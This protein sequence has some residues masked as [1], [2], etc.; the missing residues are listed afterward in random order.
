M[1]LDFTADSQALTIQ[2][3]L[4][5]KTTNDE[6]R[7]ELVRNIITEAFQHGTLSFLRSADEY[8][9]VFTFT[10]HNIQGW[11]EALPFMAMLL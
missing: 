1:V 2:V 10:F 9:E 5:M 8:I 6:V 3:T 11:N 4:A 7:G